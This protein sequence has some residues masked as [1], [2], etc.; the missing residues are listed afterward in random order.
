MG[1]S[2]L[3]VCWGLLVMVQEEYESED[4]EDGQLGS[5]IVVEEKV[6]E[7]SFGNVEDE[8]YQPE[9]EEVEGEV[10]EE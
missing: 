1:F 9:N 7:R 5:G 8:E 3:V 2:E 10:D 6:V 4:E